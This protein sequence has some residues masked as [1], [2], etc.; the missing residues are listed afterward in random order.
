VIAAVRGTVLSVTTDS[1]VV[2]VGG[3]GLLLH[4]TPAALGLMRVGEQV[5]VSTSLVVRE[6]SLTLYGFA[7]AD[8]RA[9]FESVQTVS[10]IGPRIAQAMLAAL[11]P[12]EIRRAV[13]A[14]DIK[15]LTA[16]PG[17]GQKGAQRLV[18]ELR[19][20]LAPPASDYV[21]VAAAADG[22][23]EQVHAAL[24][25]LG[26]GSREADEAVERVRVDVEAGSIEVSVPLLL[27]A[28]LRSLDRG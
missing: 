28:A 14:G 23:A 1:A 22:W 9:I 3:V 15:A 24:V 7:D 4:C 2:E 20:R 13:S 12:M 18:L 10:G 19:D 5:A 27:R 26:W 17:I 11:A 6:E 25:G 21:P 8:E 16:V